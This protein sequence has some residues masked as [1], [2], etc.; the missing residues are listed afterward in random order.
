MRYF[1]LALLCCG[2]S[3]ADELSPHVRIT[4]GGT[5]M[6]GIVVGKNEVLTAAHAWTN[7]PVKVEFVGPEESILR[8]GEVI[9]VDVGRD[10]AIVKVKTRGAKVVQLGQVKSKR[11]VI[12][13]FRG[14]DAEMIEMRGNVLVD[15]PASGSNGEPLLVVDCQALSGLSGSGVLDEETG[16]LIGVQSAGSKK[17][18]CAT[19]DQI[20]RFFLL[21]PLTR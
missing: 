3:S 2:V 9:A 6:S 12:R 7:G 21:H 15:D 11:A 20:G 16:E 19:P 8:W 14:L 1:I 10:I 4:R 13:G 17:T 18:Y 5:Q